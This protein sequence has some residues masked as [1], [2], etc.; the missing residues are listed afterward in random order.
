MEFASTLAETVRFRAQVV[1][2]L[3]D[4][5][6]AVIESSSIL[7]NPASTVAESPSIR[8]GLASVWEDLSYA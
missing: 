6:P 2:M 5:P 7:T 8:A 1:S 3:A 4:H